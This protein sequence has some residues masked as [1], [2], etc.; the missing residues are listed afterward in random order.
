VNRSA[1]TTPGLLE[2]I[3]AGKRIEVE[4]LAGRRLELRR[5]AEQAP[6][7]RPFAGSLQRRGEVRLIAEFKR[8]SPSAGALG[9]GDPAEVSRLYE[10]GGAAAVSVLTDGAFFGGSLEDLRAVRRAVEVPVLRKDFTVDEV[11]VWEARAAG[12]DAILLIVR[13][14][15]DSRLAG[16]LELAV[17]LGFGA[18]V[19]VHDAPELERALRAGAKV[20]GVNNRDLATFTTDLGVTESLACGVPGGCILVGESGIRT[21]AD[22]DRLG[23]V[24]VDAILVGEALMRGGG[25]ST[26]AGRPKRDREVVPVHRAC[27]C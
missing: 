17:E 13:I 4:G 14:L 1:R 10:A 26:L 20:I 2:R 6:P 16:L 18:L 3:V 7:A 15:E 22:V 23:A 27:S 19:E 25:V 11:Q 24:G 8:R 9:S 5:A 12:A 21:P